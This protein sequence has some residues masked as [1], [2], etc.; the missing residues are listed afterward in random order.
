MKAA[1]VSARMQL[2]HAQPDFDL[3]QDY[4]ALGL[5]AALRFR[6]PWEES[7]QPR[8]EFG[9]WRKVMFRLKDDLKEKTGTKAAIDKI[10]EAE[11]AEAEGDTDK[12]RKASEDVIRMLDDLADDTTNADDQE[13]LRVGA[14]SLGEV[15]ARLPMP[16]GDVATKM[17]FTALPVELRDLIEDIVDRAA[18][19]MDQEGFQEV[20]GDL[21][22]Y[23]SGGDYLDSDE[24]QSHLSRIIRSLV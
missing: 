17:K 11:D 23:M 8:D 16:Q 12:A 19:K 6:R 14:K 4:V 9:R 10:E 7:R 18:A 24:I 20:A 21:K 2:N 1:S 5:T 3:V 13:M 22:G 15:I